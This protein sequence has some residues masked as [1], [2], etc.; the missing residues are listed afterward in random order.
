MDACALIS[1]SDAREILGGEV[2]PPTTSVVQGTGETVS[3]CAYAS[4]ASHR[5]LSLVVREASTAADAAAA[6]DHARGEA[7]ALTGSEPLEV[8]GIGEKAFW[9][10]GTFKQLT[11]LA[12]NAQLIVSADFGDGRDRVEGTKTVA[13][14][15]LSRR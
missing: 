4:P 3:Q 5:F 6:Y 14:K 9:T 12:K 2:S 1:R 7:K 10:G 8:A 13:R 11:V 15:A